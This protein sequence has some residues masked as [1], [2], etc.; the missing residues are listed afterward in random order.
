MTL[1]VYRR[2]VRGLVAA[3]GIVGLPAPAQAQQL[4]SVWQSTDVG[5]VGVAG[6]AT[7]SEGTFRVRGAGA[8]VW[9]ASDAFHFVYQPIGGDGWIEARV[10]AIDGTEN[11]TKVGIM[12]RQSLAP[13][14]AHQFLVASLGKG[15]AY[16]RRTATGGSTVS[17]GLGTGGAGAVFRIERS[18][19]TLR[20]QVGQA[21]EV[22]RAG[23]EGVV[24][25]ETVATAPFPEGPAFVGL[26]TS[27]HDD[28]RLAAGTFDYVQV[29]GG[30]DAP[31][32]LLVFPPAHGQVVLLGEPMSIE[33][34]VGDDF[35]ITR[36]D[37]FARDDLSTPI[38]GCSN[39][40][41]DERICTWDDP[42]PPTREAQVFLRAVDSGGNQVVVASDPFVIAGPGG[43]SLPPNWHNLDIGAVGAAGS[44]NQLDGV[45]TIEGSGADVWGAADELH[46][47]YTLI[48]H[49]FEF[50]A[51]VASVENL[52]R[53]TKAG[54]ML[55]ESLQPGSRHAFAIA[56]PR[57][58]RG[59]VFQRRP[60]ED[61]Q[62]VSTTGALIAPP[63]WLKLLRQGDVV[64]AYYR[65]TTTDVWTLIARQTFTAL[66]FA[67]EVG[68]A[69]SSHVD[70][71]LATAVF[72]NVEILRT[73]RDQWQS[74][75]IGAVG[76][77]GRTGTDPITIE[78]EGAGADIWGTADAFRFRYMQMDQIGHIRV[79]VRSLENVHRWTKAGIMFR[80]TL[81]PNS[82]YVMVVVTPGKGVTMQY[83]AETGGPSATRWAVSGAVPE[84]LQ[85]S[86]AGG[87]FTGLR[88][89]DDGT[90]SGGS[91]TIP[92]ATVYV[93]LVVTSHNSSALATAVFDNLAA[94][95]N[96]L[97]EFVRPF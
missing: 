56:T 74:R 68:F 48:T 21:G 17:T 95:P 63:V 91:V 53:W 13:E 52:H 82:K 7:Y 96:V 87:T 44:T 26:V 85:L 64:S 38:P 2:L 4:P 16:Q 3:I 23:E 65:R 86:R 11:W 24:T 75:D 14:S 67:L 9:G 28:T 81:D 93:G 15:L 20:V 36:F 69:M 43:G 6:S 34:S 29:R 39:L 32:Y 94:I 55:R 42:R 18:G 47:V 12:I 89:F 90:G 57:A 78:M 31:P 92:M 80:E 50:T 37:V 54:L 97:P 73:V 22:G 1:T 77:A 10:A 46:F 58:E 70:G 60:V 8:D 62:S 76:V 66:P 25:F 84:R 19:G 83:R 40:S 33:W 61:G 35:F 51:R 30:A 72:D 59:V 88:I 41:G 5:T 27:S 71:R 79:R 45:W 49:D